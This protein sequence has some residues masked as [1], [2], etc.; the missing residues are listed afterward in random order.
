MFPGRRGGDYSRGGDYRGKKGN[1]GGG[2]SHRH[3]HYKSG[4]GGS[5][6][7]HAQDSYH[8]RPRSRGRSQS[9]ASSDRK[10]SSR[11]S[12]RQSRSPGYEEYERKCEA[13]REEAMIRHRPRSSPTPWPSASRAR[14]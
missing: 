14:S 11:R 4:S 1:Y 7:S 2:G 9:Y 10:P 12:A 8:Y 6:G 5:R 3:S 13:E